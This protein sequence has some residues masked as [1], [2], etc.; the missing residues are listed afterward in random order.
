[1]PRERKLRATFSKDKVAALTDHFSNLLLDDENEGVVFQWQELKIYLLNH[2]V[3]KPLDIYANLLSS[4]P[5]SLKHILVLVELILSSST[6][7]CERCFSAMDKIKTNFKTRIEKRTLSDLLRIKGMD[8]E[9]K[10]FD[11]NPATEAWLLSAKTKKHAMKRGNDASVVVPT[12]GPS[13]SEPFQAL[14]PLPKLPQMDS[15]SESDSE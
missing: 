4:R 15:S 10:D 2:Q 13:V 5:D 1:M 3:M 8:L 12:D 14:P 9:M 6:A 11:P 7:K